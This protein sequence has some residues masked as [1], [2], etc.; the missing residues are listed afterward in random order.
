MINTLNMPVSV[1]HAA[2]RI[3]TNVKYNFKS[4]ATTGATGAAA[5]L[6]AP[7]VTPQ[8]AKNFIKGIAD[9]APQSKT[10]IG[11]GLSY[12]NNFIGQ[13]G[14][15]WNAL[16]PKAKVIVGAGIAVLGLLGLK[17]SYDMGQIDGKHQTVK[18]MIK[19]TNESGL[20]V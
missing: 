19:H 13:T 8:I 7:K 4:L 1:S 14:T 17:H 2:D 9:Y 18:E 20:Y 15:A 16:P 11:K 10:L 12:I 3:K 6:V 5:Y